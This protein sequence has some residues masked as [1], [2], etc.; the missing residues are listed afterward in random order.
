MVTGGSML[1][2]F[3]AEE[4]LDRVQMLCVCRNSFGIFDRDKPPG[5]DLKTNVDRVSED[6]GAERSWITDDYE[7]EWYFPAEA[8]EKLWGVCESKLAGQRGRPFYG[9]L[10]DAG[11]SVGERPNKALNAR[12]VLEFIAANDGVD[13]PANFKVHLDR[14]VRFVRSTSVAPPT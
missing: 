1:A 13:W 6:L 8:V 7:F 14:L 2:R 4:D 12:R 9:A 10:R 11:A 5:Q 3:S